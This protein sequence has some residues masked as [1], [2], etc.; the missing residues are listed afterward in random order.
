VSNNSKD[1]Q[2]RVFFIRHAPTATTG[3]VLYGRTT[4]L[5]LSDQGRDYARLL[6]EHLKDIR[7]DSIY[8]SPLER[9]LQT[10]EHILAGRDIELTVRDELIDTHN[11]T[12][13][14]MTLADC[15][16]LEEWKIVQ[17]HPSQFTFPDGE[18]FF[19]V[20]TRMDEI[21][22]SIVSFNP[23]KNVAIV[24][25]RD[26]IIL[27]LSSYLGLH[28]DLFQRIPCTPASLSE[29]IFSNGTARVQSINVLPID[30]MV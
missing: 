9:A 29:V 21:V 22:R 8:S 16:K 17:E 6:G 24:C 2:T 27:L 10:A 30:R 1:I 13:T 14:N 4:G 3:K 26:P 12:W 19:D 18:S 7:I 20:L 28:M 11:G 25:H 23:N 15:A 5:D